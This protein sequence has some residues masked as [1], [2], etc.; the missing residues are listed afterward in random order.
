MNSS[1][2]CG[3]REARHW[4]AACLIFAGLADTARAQS[5]WTRPAL[6]ASENVEMGGAWGEA[7]ARGE[8]RIG[9]DPY[10]VTYLLADLNFGMHRPF[11]NFSGDVSGRFLE[12]A[13]LTSTRAH[14]QPAALREVM[15]EIP[16]LQ[17]ADG[18]FGT[19]VDWARPID[20]DA[21][22]EKAKMMPTLWGNGRM[23][24][25]LIA[26]YERFGDRRILHCARKLG[27][28]YADIA[29][30]RFCDPKR[31]EEYR[32]KSGGYAGAY[33]TC[34][35]TGIEGLAKLHHLTGDKKYLKAAERMAD[36]HAAF[37]TLP[38]EHSHGSICVHEALLMLYEATGDMKYLARVTDRW[39]KAV[40]G[41]YVNPAGG[42]LEKFNVSYNSSL[43]EGCAEAD[44]LR[45]NLMLWRNTGGTQYLDMAERSL[46]NEFP[47]N[48]WP[49]GGFGHR[50]VSTDAKGAYAFGKYSREAVWCCCFH[51]PLAL[52]EL[53]SYLA[54]GG[55]TG[56]YYNFPADFK[57][58][59]QVGRRAWTVTSKVRVSEDGIPAR[60][61][62]AVAGAGRVS[63]LVRIPEWAGEVVIESTGRTM[64]V[65]KT[66]GYLCTAPISPK[67]KLEIT[68]HARLYFENR[69]G[70]RLAVPGKLPLTLQD[71][72]LRHGPSVL[73]NT[74]S[75]DIQ[76]VRLH[77]Q[78]DGS[79]E[80]TPAASANLAPWLKIQDKNTPH[81]FV[82]NAILE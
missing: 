5:V 6:T 3:S 10:T 63:V 71:V 34:V 55:A 23:L 61:E 50:H 44:W 19:D 46:W 65:I 47:A 75:G 80:L 76:S 51:G 26:A 68:Y 72:V 59:V 16:A 49:D 36:F 70:Q 53:K 52:H 14:P 32:Q 27:D 69:Q 13:S 66:N 20:F 30:G 43:D 2:L 82:F 12:V 9:L 73:F 24:L 81:A 57:A 21:P 45:L 78:A 25:G 74:D 17:K 31:V 28:F 79:M 15:E 8:K 1:A 11:T 77:A 39:S 62:V 35:Y 58:P 18:H 67:D 60:C 4:L 56:I 33:V 41:G 22:V 29:V 64:P 38:V 37:D 40:T 54:V 48:Q 7:L 42:V